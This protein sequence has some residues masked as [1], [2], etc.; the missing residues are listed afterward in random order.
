MKRLII[1]LDDTLTIKG[2]EP[3][4]QEQPNRDV[5]ARLREYKQSGFEIVIHTSRNMR[6][7]AGNVGKINVHTLPTIL[8]WLQKHEIPFD[9]V[10]VGKPWCG[11]DG[12]YIDDRALRPDEFV[13]LDYAQVRALLKQDK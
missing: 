10:V 7:H 9:E 6:T 2:G 5:I 1:D 13:N 4:G 3:Y 11:F 12:F 8:Q